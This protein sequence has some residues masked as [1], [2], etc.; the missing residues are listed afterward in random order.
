MRPLSS[1]FTLDG[2]AFRQIERRGDVALFAKRNPHHHRDTFEVVI[3]QRHPAKRIMGREYPE[4][5][6]M[7]PSEAWGAAGWSQTDL[8]SARRKFHQVSQE[9]GFPN[10]P[11]DAGAFSSANRPESAPL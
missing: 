1:V 9:R 11:S 4:R 5:E 7:P 10:T 3:I 2:F 8:E 6:S